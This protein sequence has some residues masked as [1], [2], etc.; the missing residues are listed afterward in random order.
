MVVCAKFVLIN[1]Y[2]LAC[3]QICSKLH[4]VPNCAMSKLMNSLISVVTQAHNTE[5]MGKGVEMIAQEGFVWTLMN[6]LINY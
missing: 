6:L 1:I 3:F 5:S 4:V 2:S